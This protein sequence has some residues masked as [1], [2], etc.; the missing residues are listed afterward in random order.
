MMLYLIPSEQSEI[1][2]QSW[3]MKVMF[4]AEDNTRLSSFLT[5]LCTE[6]GS[7]KKKTHADDR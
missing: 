7:L 3:S 6:K 1:S 4:W 5:G 2:V